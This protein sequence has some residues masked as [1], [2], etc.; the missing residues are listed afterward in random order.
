MKNLTYERK[1]AIEYAKK[2]SYLRNPKYYNFDLLGG[3]CT[4]FVSQCL[5]AGTNSMNYTKNFGWYYIDANNKSPSLTGVEYLYKFLVN[6]K[7]IGPYAKEVEQD[8]IEVGDIAQLSFDGEKFEHK[9]LIVEIE[10]KLSL[11]KI[12]IASHTIDNYGKA[13]SEYYFKKI[14]WI[15]IQ[16]MRKY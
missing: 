10:N 14:R 9:L 2:W 12:K 15:H 3:D 8:Q 7:S 13:I 16:G 4:N 5:Y 11:S 1:L 6:N